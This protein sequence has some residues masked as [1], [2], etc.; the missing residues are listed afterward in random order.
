MVEQAPDERRRKS[1]AQ[2]A[3][4][5]DRNGLRTIP[6]EFVRD[7]EQ[8]DRKGLAHAARQRHQQ[9]TDAEH[10]EGKAR[11]MVRRHSTRRRF[12]VGLLVH[13]QC[14]RFRDSPRDGLYKSLCLKL[15]RMP[16]VTAV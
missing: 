9:E 6:A 16:E 11:G 3:D 1:D 2:S 15:S 13:V 5:I 10:N 12:L 7:R 14:L 4:R 8:K